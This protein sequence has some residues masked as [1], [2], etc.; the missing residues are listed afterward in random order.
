MAKLVTIN[1]G[2]RAERAASKWLEE[3]LPNHWILT[4]NIDR[5]N[6][7]EVRN[8]QE[9]DGLLICPA[10]IFVLEYKNHVGRITPN[11]NKSWHRNGEELRSKDEI[12]FHKAHRKIFT[13][14]DFLKGVDKAFDGLQ[15]HELII[16]TNENVELD[17]TSSDIP[18][19]SRGHMKVALLRDVEAKINQIAS[20]GG[21]R[22]I[23]T[24]VPPG[25]ELKAIEALAPAAW[26]QGL[27]EQLQ[28]QAEREDQ[29]RNFREGQAIEGIVTELGGDATKIR[30]IAVEHRTRNHPGAL[31]PVEGIEAQMDDLDPSDEAWLSLHRRI[32]AKI[33]QI[34]RESGEIRLRHERIDSGDDPLRSLHVNT[35]VPARIIRVLDNRAEVDLGGVI[36]SMCDRDLLHTNPGVSPREVLSIDDWIEVMVLKI[37]GPNRDVGV[38]L[39]QAT[40]EWRSNARWKQFWSQQPVGSSI[41]GGL[42]AVKQ[43]SSDRNKK[44]LIVE[45]WKLGGAAALAGTVDT[46]DI[47]GYDAASQLLGDYLKGRKVRLTVRNVDADKGRVRLGIAKEDAESLITIRVSARVK[48]S[49]IRIA[50][51]R[52]F[53]DF[54]LGGVTGRLRRS[55]ESGGWLA[56]LQVGH[57][58]VGLVITQVTPDLQVRILPTTIGVGSI[59]LRGTIVQATAVTRKKRLLR[60]LLANEFSLLRKEDHEG[61]TKVLN[62]ALE[63]LRADD[64][65]MLE[66]FGAGEKFDPNLHDEIMKELKKYGVWQLYPLGEQF[67]PNLHRAIIEVRDP[68]R[69]DGSVV[70]VIQPGYM[71]DEDLLHPALV[72]V[73]RRSL[74]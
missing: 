27:R 57:K 59:N 49:V 38:S 33:I 62:M 19:R 14:K 35:Q 65:K 9:L 43:S 52:S 1:E 31:K 12:S 69:P 25:L 40:G 28:K 54:D 51:D 3:H 24:P 26:P 36:G 72:R 56:R 29:I 20:D 71:W 41:E 13:I 10:G 5:H 61:Q 50:D 66:K 37:D 64:V 48:G 73:A 7:E 23:R 45:I 67:D 15:F 11:R 8:A 44:Q 53:A 58:L 42:L 47:E 21:D 60:A 2:S 18:E 30:L 34:D 70:D 22:R 6:F 39:R 74:K 68:T 17:W 16:L 32:R 46:E 63:I 55:A 4:S